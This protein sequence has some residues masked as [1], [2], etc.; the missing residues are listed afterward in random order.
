[1]SL[2]TIDKSNG[3]TS[4]RQLNLHIITRYIW[5]Q[6]CYHS[7]LITVKIQGWDSRGEG[8]GSMKQWESLQKEY[9]KF[10]RKQ[11]QP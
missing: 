9:E 8:R 4:W 1:M 5:L 7:R 10:R 11:K 2:S 3:Q 6:K